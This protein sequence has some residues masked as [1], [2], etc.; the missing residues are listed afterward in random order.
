[1]EFIQNPHIAAQTTHLQELDDSKG[2][3]LLI[4]SIV[5]ASEQLIENV[6]NSLN[7]LSKALDYMEQRTDNI[8]IQLRALLESNRELRHNN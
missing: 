7:A 8:L 3:H 2:K 5:N 4:L 1:M 6:N